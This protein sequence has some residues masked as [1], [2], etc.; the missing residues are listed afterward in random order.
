MKLPQTGGCQCGALRYEII[1]APHI[2]CTC[3]CTDCQR[4]TSSAFSIALVL[5]AGAFRLVRGEPKAVQRVADSGRVTTRWV[6]SECGSWICGG[7]GPDSTPRNDVDH[8]MIYDA[9]CSL[10]G[11]SFAHLPIYGLEDLGFV[12]R[13]EAGTFIADRNTAPGG[14]LPLNTN[15]GGLSYMHSGMYGM[16]ALQES[17]RQ[18][19]GTAP[20]QIP[21]AKLSVCHGVGGI[22]AAS[23][24]IIMSNEPP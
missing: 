14:K 18:M 24:T 17:V 11:A 3:H 9:P 15:G 5:Q 4:M 21:G 12:P 23:G 20:A 13:G 16:Y 1:Q 2:V 6:C 22:F 10:P 19:R 7:I 8:L